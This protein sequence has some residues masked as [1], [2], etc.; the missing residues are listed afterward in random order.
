MHFN[1]ILG[2]SSFVKTFFLSRNCPLF[3]KNITEVP[4]RGSVA[5]MR[6]ILTCENLS[7]VLYVLCKRTL[8]VGEKHHAKVQ[9]SV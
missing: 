7:C 8:K 4:E 5:Q 6:G 1:I 3:L 2:N 9:K